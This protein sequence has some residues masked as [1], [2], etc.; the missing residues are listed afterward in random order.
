[1]IWTIVYNH[2]KLHACTSKCTIVSHIRLTIHGCIQNTFPHCAS[3]PLH[4]YVWPVHVRACECSVSLSVEQLRCNDVSYAHC[5]TLALQALK[6]PHAHTLASFPGPTQL[7]LPAV[8]MSIL[9]VYM[10]QVGLSSGIG[11]TVGYDGLI[12]C[13]T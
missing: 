5:Y 7:S 3:C 9:L 10:G 12:L 1:M 8:C 4:A 2:A 6:A 13:L 11:W